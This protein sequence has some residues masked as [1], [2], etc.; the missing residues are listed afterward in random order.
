[1]KPLT[2]GRL[3]KKCGVNVETIRYYHRRALLPLPPT[4]SSAYRH[5]SE[6]DI[7]RIRFIRGAQSLGFTLKEIGE[8]LS[9]RIDAATSASE[10]KRRTALKIADIE[11][12]LQSLQEMKAV[13][14]TLN[15]QCKGAKSDRSCTILDSLGSFGVSRQCCQEAE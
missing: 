15:Q 7:E 5:Y 12:K 9:L 8:L 1:M 14:T 2:I 3:A 10:V 11:R 4:T 6:N 13:L